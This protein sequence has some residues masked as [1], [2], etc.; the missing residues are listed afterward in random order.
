[1][2]SLKNSDWSYRHR[3]AYRIVYVYENRDQKSDRSAYTFLAKAH[4]PGVWVV[5]VV[6]RLV[7]RFYCK[8]S[9][10]TWTGCGNRIGA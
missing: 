1:M 7:I 9:P 10:L 3:V 5:V 6:G 2:S 8:P 4:N